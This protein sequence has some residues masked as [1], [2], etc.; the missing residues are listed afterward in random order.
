MRFLLFLICISSFCLSQN[1]ITF[2]KKKNSSRHFEIETPA[3]CDVLF[4]NGKVNGYVTDLKDSSLVIRIFNPGKIDSIKK[5]MA[6]AKKTKKDKS[7]TERE[8]KNKLV[9]YIYRDS[10]TLPL[11]VVRQVKFYSSQKKS[12]YILTYAASFIIAAGFTEFYV[13]FL[14]PFPEH[15]VTDAAVIVGGFSAILCADY[16]LFVKRIKPKKWRVLK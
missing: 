10:L 12:K 13:N 16:N 1:K 11:S 14:D 7:L 6:E 3:Y 4:L 9:K 8:R 5:I 2:E 15:D